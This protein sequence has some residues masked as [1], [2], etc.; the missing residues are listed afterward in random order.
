VP[1]A[2]PPASF[3][4]ASRCAGSAVSSTTTAKTQS[5]SAIT[6]PERST[7]ANLQPSSRVG[8]KLPSSMRK[9]STA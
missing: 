9:T 8:P 3:A 4:S 5:P 6:L 1:P 2:S 7:K